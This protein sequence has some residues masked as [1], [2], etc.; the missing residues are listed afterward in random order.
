MA[1]K[2]V[3]KQRRATS[4]E[5]S[6]NNPILDAGEFAFET[7][8]RRYKLGDGT[9]PWTD[10]TTP[11]LPSGLIKAKGD[12]IT[13]GRRVREL[14]TNLAFAIDTNSDGLVDGWTRVLGSP[15]QTAA[16]SAGQTLTSSAGMA[17]SIRY[18]VPVI[19]GRSYN[20]SLHYVLKSLGASTKQ[21][22]VTAVLYSDTTLTTVRNSSEFNAYTTGAQTLNVDLQ[23]PNGPFTMDLSGTLAI[24]LT[25]YGGASAT[26]KS[27]SFTEISSGPTRV[28]AGTVANSRLTTDIDGLAVWSTADEAASLAPY[29]KISDMVA[30]YRTQAAADSVHS[31]FELAADASATYETI[32]NAAIA[33]ALHQYAVNAA[34]DYHTPASLGAI[35]YEA[36]DQFAIATGDFQ[37]TNNATQAIASGMGFYMEANITYIFEIFLIALGTPANGMRI[38]FSAPSLVNSS[39]G[40][41]TPVPGAGVTSGNVHQSVAAGSG[42]APGTQQIGIA[43][44]PTFTTVRGT[45][46]NGA[47]AGF[48]NL[49]FAQNTAAASTS[50]TIKADSYIRA[51]K[52]V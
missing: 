17:T 14:M 7:D 4:A 29:I 19:A 1:T 44:T 50:C 41:H 49:T 8:T 33:H 46:A 31:Q 16:S 12:L 38:G 40:V 21:D 51:V 22:E 6:L 30:T 34:T 27:I 32:N 11:Y 15:A 52:A 39:W 48:C 3:Q 13:Y 45:L 42:T 35:A 28:P 23:H 9:T 18:L 43:A 26:Y 10:L 36:I 47:T 25:V 20:F 5:W 37:A 24:T 2:T